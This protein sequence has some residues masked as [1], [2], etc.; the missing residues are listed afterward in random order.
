MRV[1]REQYDAVVRR[2][3]AAVLR[4][5]SG[6]LAPATLTLGV[7]CWEVRQSEVLD[8]LAPSPTGGPLAASARAWRAVLRVEAAASPRAAA[9]LAP[10][11]RI[12]DEALGVVAL[13]EPGPRRLHLL[14]KGCATHIR[15]C[16]QQKHPVPG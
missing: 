7:S 3:A 14:Q 8:L 9:A 4:R 2:E 5:E 12:G 1:A 15:V 13:E 16:S 11:S 6:S 10:R